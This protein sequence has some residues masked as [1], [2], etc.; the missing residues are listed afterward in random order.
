MNPGASNA[1]STIQPLSSKN[2]QTTGAV[3]SQ[4][5]QKRSLNRDVRRR[6]LIKITLENQAFLRRLQNKT[7]NYNVHKWEEEAVERKR[8]LRNICEYDYIID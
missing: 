1:F 5:Q 3:I 2:G 6:E 7:S 4:Q 8:I